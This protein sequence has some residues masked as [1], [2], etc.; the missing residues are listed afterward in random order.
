MRVCVTQ[1]TEKGHISG[2]QINVGI[3]LKHDPMRGSNGKK[4]K[5]LSCHSNK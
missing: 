3:L 2:I 5:P 4:R 1:V